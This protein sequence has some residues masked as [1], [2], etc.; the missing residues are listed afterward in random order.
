M[1]MPFVATTVSIFD[2]LLLMLVVQYAITATAEKHLKQIHVI[3]RHGSSTMLPKDADTLIEEDGSTLTPL[4]QSQLYNLGSWLRQTYL[5]QLEDLRYYN[6][7]FH[8]LEST[9]MDRTLSSANALALG[10]FPLTQ[11]AT[12]LLLEDVNNNLEPALLTTSL[13]YPPA[14]PVYSIDE[15]NDVYLRAFQ[16]CPTFFDNLQ[17]LY[18]TPSWKQLEDQHEPLLRKLANI[19]PESSEQGKVPLKEVWNVYEEIHVAVTECTDNETLCDALV[20]LPSL[21]TAIS[22]QDFLALEL[23][24][25]QVEHMKYAEPDTAGNLLGSNLLWKILERAGN[26]QIGGTVFLY[27][28]HAPTLLGILS[29]LQAAEDFVMAT[30]GERFV[31]YGSALIVEVYQETAD[32]GV[33]ETLFLKLKYVSSQHDEAV[34]IPL[35]PCGEDSVEESTVFCE[36]TEFTMWALEHTLVGTEHWCEACGNVDSDVCLRA[37]Y[38]T[39]EEQQGDGNVGWDSFGELEAT[40]R[41]STDDR[42]YALVL[43]AT[44]LGGLLAGVVLAALIGYACGF[45]AKTN[46]HAQTSP[47]NNDKIAPTDTFDPDAFPSRNTDGIVTVNGNNDN[48]IPA[49]KGGN[50]KLLV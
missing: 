20:P 48:E 49:D 36:L 40:T 29:T 14:I 1:M 28:A 7:S 22:V 3:S 5:S 26:D 21:A 12:G 33:S 19:F 15:G 43:T 31:D 23:L 17:L 38:E 8:R 39:D 47:P 45:T 37:K 35:M 18:E 34:S 25:H 30:R 16:L 41:T 42:N 32:G 50:T 10:L 2:V 11:R 24:T 9:N 27:S 46:K 6:P 44:F 13:E 4:G